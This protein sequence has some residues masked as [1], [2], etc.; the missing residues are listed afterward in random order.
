M[1]A[2]TLR[3]A[4]QKSFDSTKAR[5]IKKYGNPDIESQAEDALFEKMAE[6]VENGK[7]DEKQAKALARKCGKQEYG[8]FGLTYSWLQYF[9]R[10]VLGE[11]YDWLIAREFETLCPHR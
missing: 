10:E 7:L 6:L 3:N 4:Y 2:Q 1:T 8:E 5:Q 9:L 11:K